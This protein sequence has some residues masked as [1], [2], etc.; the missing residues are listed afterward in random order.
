MLPVLLL[1]LLLLACVA[2]AAGPDS[3]WQ[4]PLWLLLQKTEEG[5]T[6]SKHAMIIALVAGHFCALPMCSAWYKLFRKCNNLMS[7][8]P[9]MVCN[10]VTHKPDYYHNCSTSWLSE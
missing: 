4:Q 9:N 10:Q 7:H 1:L 6:A 3:F 2:P 5:A 8:P